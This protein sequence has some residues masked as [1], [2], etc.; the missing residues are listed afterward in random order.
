MFC[1][2]TSHWLDETFVSK[3]IYHHFWLGLMVGAQTM[4]QCNVLNIFICQPYQIHCNIKI[5]ND[6]QCVYEKLMI[7][8]AWYLN[9]L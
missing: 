4:G 7:I 5:V 3:I 2:S 6:L 8:Q 9:F 1:S